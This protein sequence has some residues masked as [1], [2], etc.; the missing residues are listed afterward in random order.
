MITRP[1]RGGTNIFPEKEKASTSNHE[2]RGKFKAEQDGSGGV[3]KVASPERH[4][5]NGFQSLGYSKP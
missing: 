5:D 3:G 1:K 4:G 2:G